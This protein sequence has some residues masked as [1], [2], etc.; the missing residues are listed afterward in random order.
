[1]KWITTL[2]ILKYAK[3]K[4]TGVLEIIEEIEHQ[5]SKDNNLL[6]NQYQTAIYSEVI[7][8]FEYIEY[9]DRVPQ[10]LPVNDLS[11]LFWFDFCGAAIVEQIVKYTHKL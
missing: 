11:I 4:D 6:N 9:L 7:C 8:C 2:L 5:K 10:S 1:M 3:D